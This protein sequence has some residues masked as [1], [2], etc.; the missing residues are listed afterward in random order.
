MRGLRTLTKMGMRM[1]AKQD[2]QLAA[3]RGR[4]NGT[5]EKLKEMTENLNALIRMVDEI[6]RRGQPPLA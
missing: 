6:I 2:E 1:L 5:D 3:T 4:L